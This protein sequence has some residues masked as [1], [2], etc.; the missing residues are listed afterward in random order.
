ML[1]LTD[2]FVPEVVGR[3][4]TDAEVRD[5][6]PF[7]RYAVAADGGARPDRPAAGQGGVRVMDL[8]GL[9]P[10]TAEPMWPGSRHPLPMMTTGARTTP[11]QD[12]GR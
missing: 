12:H 8:S 3:Y 4:Q 7:G 5:V 9:P 1:D 11:R 2:P 6:K 10:E